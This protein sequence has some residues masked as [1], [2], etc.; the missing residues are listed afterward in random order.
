MKYFLLPVIALALVSPSTAQ[1]QPLS[2]AAEFAYRVALQNVGAPDLCTS[3]ER[4]V[5][6]NRGTSF[7]GETS[8]PPATPEP[9]HIFLAR[10]LNPQYEFGAACF[11]FY[12]MLAM[13]DGWSWSG[14]YAPHPCR[15]RIL[16]LLNHPHYPERRF[17]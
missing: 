13:L 16:W 6:P 8:I 15:V 5:I 12:R 14:M 1:A 4:G 9:C 3:I 11:A 10:W 17:G 7:A 2:P